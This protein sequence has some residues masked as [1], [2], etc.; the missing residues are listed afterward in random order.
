MDLA[1][2]VSLVERLLSLGLAITTE[3]TDTGYL[4]EITGLKTVATGVGETSLEALSHA[5]LRFS[6][7]N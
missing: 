3:H 6:T 1:R 2:A 5:S 4:C 7:L